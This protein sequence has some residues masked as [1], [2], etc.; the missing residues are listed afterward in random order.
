MN[1]YHIETQ[2]KKKSDAKYAVLP[3]CP[4]GYAITNFFHQKLKGMPANP[5]NIEDL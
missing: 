4:S 1:Y 2:H 3:V 5:Q